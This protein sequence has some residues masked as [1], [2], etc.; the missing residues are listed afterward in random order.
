MLHQSIEEQV[1]LLVARDAD[2]L[3]LAAN[4]SPKLENSWNSEDCR[5]SGDQ[6]RPD[7]PRPRR[8]VLA[9]SGSSTIIGRMTAEG[10][11]PPEQDPGSVLCSPESPRLR[12]R[13]T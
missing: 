10:P 9:A 7:G 1:V 13:R 4:G 11:L 6:R 5:A 8:L 12:D 3:S 2:R